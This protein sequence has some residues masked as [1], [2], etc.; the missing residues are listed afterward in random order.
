MSKV[1]MKIILSLQ[2]I[3]NFLNKNV[4]FSKL[5]K[6]LIIR[7]IECYQLLPHRT[8][9][10]KVFSNEKLKTNRKLLPFSYFS[11]QFALSGKSDNFH[12]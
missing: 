8:S 11:K 1:R 6:N 10:S 3:Q 5:K 2:D 4:I 7:F 9:C 12:V